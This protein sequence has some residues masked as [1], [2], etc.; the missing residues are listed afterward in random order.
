[1]SADGVVFGN[2]TV[3]K[4]YQPG[5]EILGVHEVWYYHVIPWATP[6][7]LNY[8]PGWIEIERCTPLL[9]LDRETARSYRNNLWNL[10]NSIHEVGFWH[11]DIILRNVVV[12]PQRGILRI[13]WETATTATSSVSYDLS[14][15]QAA[16]VESAHPARSLD[17]VWWG[18][19]E[20]LS[21]RVY[22]DES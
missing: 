3:V 11:R 13:A 17:G 8:G 22:L 10:L 7:L 2:D 15:A 4:H 12:H 19:P 20:D 5:T 14:G 9:D 1:M 16:G 18:A 6:A 21:P